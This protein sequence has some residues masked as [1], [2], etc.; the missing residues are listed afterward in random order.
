M[1][2]SRP[3]RYSQLLRFI[4]PV[5]HTP[6]ERYRIYKMMRLSISA[7]RDGTLTADWGWNVSLTPLG[8]FE[9][10]THTLKF[11]ALLSEDVPEVEL[12]VN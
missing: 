12:V 8:S 1:T 6:E 3:E 2:S 5:D 9:F 4:A 7:D 10:T 11:R